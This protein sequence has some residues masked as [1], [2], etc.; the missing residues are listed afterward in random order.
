MDSFC[1]SK[2]NRSGHGIATF[3]PRPFNYS[4]LLRSNRPPS[5]QEIAGIVADIDI[6][7][8]EVSTLQ[9]HITELKQALEVLEADV[10][11]H[12]AILH[13]IRRVQSE[14]LQ[15]VFQLSSDSAVAP[16][17]PG[18]DTRSD[19]ALRWE[20]GPWNLTHVSQ[21][22]RDI[23]TSYS[24]LWST[25][26]ISFS[27]PPQRK[28]LLGLI[29]RYAGSSPLDITFDDPSSS[30]HA[31]PIGP[32]LES[33]LPTSQQW[34]SLHIISPDLSDFMPIHRKLDSLEIL[35][36]AFINDGAF[37]QAPESEKP[38]TMFEVAPMLKTVLFRDLAATPPPQLQLPWSTITRYSS[39]FYGP[40]PNGI[41]HPESLRALRLGPNLTEVEISTTRNVSETLLQPLKLLH[42]E[43]LAITGWRPR[44][45]QLLMDKLVLPALTELSLD[46]ARPGTMMPVDLGWLSA[47]QLRTD[48]SLTYLSLARLELGHPSFFAFL[49]NASTITHLKLVDCYSSELISRL[50]SDNPI[51]PPVILPNLTHL[52]MVCS[53]LDKLLHY[54]ERDKFLGMIESR[55]FSDLDFGCA[56]L[57][58]AENL[59]EP[60][61]TDH[62]LTSEQVARIA[63]LRQ[64]GLI[65]HIS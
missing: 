47:A 59:V 46:V 2:G 62:K 53:E 20:N 52:S 5:E 17:I 14:I 24:D 1:P 25:I 56:K 30:W 54:S 26:N 8:Q 9:N 36:V 29:L 40:D 21:Q 13:P 16:C 57:V 22:W 6:R 33:L 39:G 58:L 15:E 19:I 44:D 64:S 27:G 63:A 51:P 60:F 50:D 55:S 7:E 41:I 18:S 31:C 28:A 32:I 61:G 42:L 3:Q 37:R 35:S 48:F 43:N 38:L 4:Q 49:S 11:N 65:L 45:L 34:R 23:S 12:K 10:L